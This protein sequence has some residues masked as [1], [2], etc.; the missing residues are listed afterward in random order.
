MRRFLIVSVMMVSVLGSGLAQSPNEPTNSLLQASDGN[1]YGF[2]QDGFFSLTPGGSYTVLNSKIQGTLCLEAPD[3]SLYAVSGGY[4]SATGKDTA[5]QIFKVT[6]TGESSLVATLPTGSS[7]YVASC[8]AMANDGNYY[9]GAPIGGSHGYGFLYQLTPAGRVTVFYNFRGGADG[10]GPSAAPLQASDGNLYGQGSKGMFRYD[11][12]GGLS[13][14]G[15]GGDPQAAPLVQ[16]VDGNFYSLETIPY[17]FGGT[18]YTNETDVIQTTPTG[19]GAV[20]YSVIGNPVEAPTPMIQALSAAGDGSIS[21]IQSNQNPGICGEGNTLEGAELGVPTGN[22]AWTFQIGITPPWSESESLTY[23]ASNFLLS[24]SGAYYGVVNTVVG[25]GQYCNN[26]Y[27]S[28]SIVTEPPVFTPPIAMSL[29]QT[30]VLPGGEGRSQ[31][32]IKSPNDPYFCNYA[33]VK[34]LGPQGGLS[35]RSGPS[36]KDRKIDILVEGQEVYICDS[37]LDWDKIVYQDSSGHCARTSVHGLDVRLTKAC[38]TGWV[39]DQWIDILS[40]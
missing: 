27:T 14:I 35:V 8:I 34:A 3:E 28:N 12:S 10:S 23:T 21:I 22:D 33:K 7:Q 20:I 4:D 25:S 32:P 19:G 36:L 1:L 40:G 31:M 13:V 5:S 17:N 30:H 26:E 24:G 2:D 16:G 9:G 6:L 15:G 18:S 39:K 11:P 38:K 29:Y 37:H